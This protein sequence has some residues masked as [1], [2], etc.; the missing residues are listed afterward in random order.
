MQYAQHQKHPRFHADGPVDV[1]DSA[2]QIRRLPLTNISLGGMFIQTTRPS[3]PGT[4]VRLRLHD[5]SAVAT[6]GLSARVIH[7]IDPTLSAQKRHPPGMGLQFENV[8]PQSQLLL[9]VFVE[10]LAALQEAATQTTT[11]AG[12]RFVSQHTVQVTLAR[13]LFAE[14][15]QQSLRYGG[16]FA[17]GDAPPL[18][19]LVEVNIGALSLQA[20]VVHVQ[21]GHGAGLQV[22]NLDG[23]RRTSIERYLD[24]HAPTIEA[25]TT[26]V[27]APGGP[28]LGKV[29][30]IVRQLF[31]GVETGAV[32][33]AVSL[34]T[35]ATEDDV[36]KR[37][38]SLLRLFQ[39]NRPDATP[40]QNARIAA[41][42]RA[43]ARLEPE[44]L[45]RVAALR[46]EAEIVPTPSAP[47]REAVQRHIQQ[48]IAAES[49]GE[50]L[51]ARTLLRAALELAP[52]D[53]DVK[54]RLSVLQEKIDTFKA[55]DLLAS[56]DVI[57]SGLGMRDE[58]LRRAGEALALSTVPDVRKR[59]AS[60]YARAGQLEEAIRLLE[61]LTR[62]Q[63]RDPHTLNALVTL[64][65]RTERWSRALAAMN[66]L[67]RFRPDDEELKKR[68]KRIAKMCGA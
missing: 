42:A 33:E 64:Y 10:H 11:P 39:P 54:R 45:T 4:V 22:T 34:P 61:E 59:A 17:E 26:S 57:V 24:G 51:E 15:W 53:A 16:L 28:P 5:K 50:K 3:S 37:V 38:Q 49:R 30:A 27:P 48:A 43:L 65:E 13:P 46:R 47:D 25:V 31:A 52:D 68:A 60:I 8:T 41:A 63:P 36:R 21:P 32:F 58:A 40:P 7:I 67:L 23:A 62:E 66:A 29:L 44:L 55:I 35:S 6:L 56:A 14:L 20:E 19:A 9:K 2:A 12:V 1:V 18:G